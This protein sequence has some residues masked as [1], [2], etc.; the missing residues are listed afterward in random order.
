[1]IVVEVARRSGIHRKRLH[2]WRTAFEVRPA[3]AGQASEA[4]G[5]VPVTVLSEAPKVCVTNNIIAIV[6]GSVS[7]RLT[8]AVDV[9]AL[10]QVLEVIGSLI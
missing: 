9:A 1:M 7:D 2:G 8:G 3:K 6:I 10:R 5:F 4:L